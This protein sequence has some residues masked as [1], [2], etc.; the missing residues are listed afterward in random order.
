MRRHLPHLLAFVAALTSASA[1][2]GGLG[3]LATAGGHVD[4]VYSYTYNETTAQ[5]DQFIEDQMNA[6]YGTGL[7][8]ILGD[9]DNKITGSF[10]AYYLA[11]A[12]MQEPAKGQVYA[13]RKTTRSI[14][15]LDAGLQFGFL[16]EP[17]A[18][19]LAALAYVGSGFLTV[20]YTPFI[21]GQAGV[22]VTWMAARHVQA[23]ASATGGARYHRRFYPTVTGNLGVRYMFD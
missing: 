10:R 17:D 2:A 20:D 23:F 12:P 3:L 18:I 7:E 1:H 22:G 13:V 6:N 14:G 19:Q 5:D 15:V 11:D 9:K 8:L 4:R 21:S 16:G